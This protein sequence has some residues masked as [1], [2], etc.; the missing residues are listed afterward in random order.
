MLRPYKVVAMGWI[1][2][3]DVWEAAMSFDKLGVGAG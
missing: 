1:S 2:C 3:G